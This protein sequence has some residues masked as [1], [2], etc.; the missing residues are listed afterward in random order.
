MLNSTVTSK[1][2]KVLFKLLHEYKNWIINSNNNNNSNDD[3]GLKQS[4]EILY[5]T[6]ET[7][8]LNKELKSILKTIAQYHGISLFGID[9]CH[10]ISQW[11]HT[12]RPKYMELKNIHSEYKNVPICALTATATNTIVKD[13]I[14]QLSMVNPVKIVGNFNRPN[15]YL[16]FKYVE[17]L[18]PCKSNALFKDIN[19][20]FL[21][22][23]QDIKS[24]ISSKYMNTCG[25][26]YVWTRNDT[27][28]LYKL[29]KDKLSI[30]YYHA[31][32]SNNDRKNIQTKWEKSEIKIIIATN[33]FGMGID[34]SDVRFIIHTSIPKSLEHY[35][36]EIGRASRDGKQG[37]I[38]CYYNKSIIKTWKNIIMNTHLNRLKKKDKYK[39]L[40]T[41][42]IK[43]EVNKLKQYQYEISNLEYVQQFAEPNKCRRTILLQY[44]GNK[45]SNKNN[46]KCCDYCDDSSKIRKILD[47]YKLQK[48]RKSKSVGDMLHDYKNGS[49]F[50][51][52]FQMLLTF[53]LIHLNH[54]HQYFY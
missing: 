18:K 30:A 31:G 21:K 34:K 54:N 15:L 13:V 10:C 45:Y 8:F 26:I 29:L 28:T 23:A 40:S 1:D 50:V 20:Q 39:K 7:L 53:H 5:T 48:K 51:Q 6:P 49:H 11:G 19:P 36:Q 22:I 32:M 17:T 42:Q 35:Y 9:E 43:K 2:K 38:V 4:I 16:S 12:F 41:E 25:L 52:L 24:F 47:G 37:M 27:E 33:A 44:F 46:S 3:L 14:K